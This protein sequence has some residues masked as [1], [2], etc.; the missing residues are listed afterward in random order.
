MAISDIAAE[1]LAD[2]RESARASA[3]AIRAT[4]VPG[5]YGDN[6]S[7]RKLVALGDEI[8]RAELRNLSPLLSEFNALATEVMERDNPPGS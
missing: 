7:V 4:V 2:T 8:G 5:G 3:A 1:H 6:D